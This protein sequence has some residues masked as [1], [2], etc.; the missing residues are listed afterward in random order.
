MYKGLVIFTTCCEIDSARVSGTP[1]SGDIQ[2]FQ[3]V[4][5]LTVFFRLEHPA[6]EEGANKN[7]FK[8]RQEIS[9]KIYPG[10]KIGRWSTSG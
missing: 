2:T 5:L 4:T 8:K 3:M 6:N 7:S 10:V 9:S 1:K